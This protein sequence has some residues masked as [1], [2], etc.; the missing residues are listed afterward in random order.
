MEES[1]SRFL[2]FEVTLDLTLSRDELVQKFSRIISGAI[3]D[4]KNQHEGRILEGS[5]AKRAFGNLFREV[6]VNEC[7]SS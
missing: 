6:Q 3:K 1:E 5:V 4:C 7:Q 2:V